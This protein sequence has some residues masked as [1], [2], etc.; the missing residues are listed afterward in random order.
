MNQDLYGGIAERYDL[1]HGEFGQ[2]NPKEVEFYR[3]LF[4][5]Q[6]VQTVLDCACGTGRHL[7]LFHSLGQEVVGSDISASMLAQA[8]KNLAARDLQIPLHRVDY[9]DL[10]QHFHRRFDAVV[11]LSSSILHMPDDDQVLRALRSMRG[12]L[13]EGGLLVLTQGT[14]DRQWTEKP[15]FIL[16]VNTRDFSRLFVIDYV[17][18]GARYNVLDIHHNEEIDELQTWSIEYPRMLLKDDQEELLKAAGFEMINFYGSYRFEP[19]DKASSERLIAVAHN[20]AHIDGHSQE[21]R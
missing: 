19:Y 3:Q 16:A 5:Q 12:V 1:F 13:R 21:V 18:A 11:C 7:H 8:R 14:T 4:A 10:P 9:R 17:G 20:G 2:H 15:R 6:G